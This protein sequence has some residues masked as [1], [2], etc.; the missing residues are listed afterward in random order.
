M[1][2]DLSALEEQ[3]RKCQE[4]LAAK[5]AKV[6][7]LKDLLRRSM[8]AE[9][10]REQ[11]VEAL[12]LDVDSRDRQVQALAQEIEDKNAFITRQTER[13]EELELEITEMSNRLRTGA[14]SEAAQ[15]RSERMRQMVE[16]SSALYA[17]LQTRYRQV[18]SDLEDERKKK[19]AS[20]TPKRVIVLSDHEALTLNNNGTFAPREAARHLPPDVVVHDLRGRGRQAK[21]QEPPEESLLKVYLRGVLLE[22]FIADSATQH[23]LVP[24]MLQLLDCSPEQIAAAQ[25]GFAEGKQIIAKAAA[26][27]GF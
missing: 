3:I 23:R 5:H 10:R 13:I 25:R 2:A 12:Q 6:D 16:R 8:R 14:G 7:K 9:K 22:F 11:Q 20:G 15:K 21:A 4:D 19:S 18:C 17:D 26:A 27:L 24:V 1:E